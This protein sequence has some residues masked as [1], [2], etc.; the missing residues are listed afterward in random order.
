MSLSKSLFSSMQ[1][2]NS[3]E[4]DELEK[5]IIYTQFMS[6]IIVAIVQF[7]LEQV[8]FLALLST[9]YIVHTNLQ[10]LIYFDLIPISTTVLIVVITYTILKNVKSV[11]TGI[12]VVS[13]SQLV[14]FSVA[15]F[16]HSLF[17]MFFMLFIIPIFI[18]CVYSQKK[19][20]ITLGIISAISKPAID[21]ILR[22]E[23]IHS[24]YGVH[25]ETDRMVL[26]DSL[27]FIIAVIFCV[28]LCLF[29]IS[30]EDKRNTLERLAKDGLTGLYNRNT[31]MKM[32]T[33]FLVGYNNGVLILIDLDGFKSVNDKQG[34]PFG[35]KVLM[36][37]AEIIKNSFRINDCVCRLGGDEFLIYTPGM[38]I[39]MAKEKVQKMID[40]LARDFTCENGDVIHT[41]ASVGLA[42]YPKDGNDAVSLYSAADRALYDAK[43]A[44]KGNF[45]IYK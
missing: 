28:W 9:S 4:Y 41:G 37:S 7:V 30:T 40:A 23:P 19:L 35:D 31:A 10:Y 21:F 22:I 38:T 13:I 12:W 17:Q 29:I 39:D 20:T 15:Y 8:V 26:L 24:L 44:G 11:Y 18:S 3:F 42:C 1:S 45:K 25:L 43:L 6:I 14:I 27:M 32:M 5:K 33:N 34:H 2:T 36:E 16:F